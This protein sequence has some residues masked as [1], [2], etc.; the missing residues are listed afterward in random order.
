MVIQ[1]GVVVKV[2][3]GKKRMAR[4]LVRGK[5]GI[6]ESYKGSQ[7]MVASMCHSR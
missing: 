5:G 3:L 4:R 1:D 6:V 7:V 2:D